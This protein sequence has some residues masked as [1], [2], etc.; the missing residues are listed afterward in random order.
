M[1]FQCAASTGVID[2]LL[3]LRSN[4][5]PSSESDACSRN[6]ASDMKCFI[7]R[8]SF[9]SIVYQSGLFSV[10]FASKYWLRGFHADGYQSCRP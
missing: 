10:L 1:N 7:R 2:N 3:P 4:S 5:S 9:T 6:D 8:F